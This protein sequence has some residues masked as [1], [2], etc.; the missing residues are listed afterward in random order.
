M[1]LRY[2][3]ATCFLLAGFLL[4]FWDPF[5]APSQQGV[6][7]GQFSEIKNDI[8]RKQESTLVWD[9]VSGKK[10]IYEGDGIYSGKESMATI[11]INGQKI[12]VLSNSL[13]FFQGTSKK[14]KVAQGGLSG[15]LLKETKV[16]LPNGTVVEVTADNTSLITSKNQ[17]TSS[18]PVQVTVDNKT[19]TLDENEFFDIEKKSIQECSIKITTENLLHEKKQFPIALSWEDPQNINNY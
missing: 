7:I 8:R 15:S 6:Q 5:Q 17:I 14:I 18:L 13:I 12:N 3:Y 9:D 10:A 16:E 19:L 1:L 2:I 4:F 11:Q